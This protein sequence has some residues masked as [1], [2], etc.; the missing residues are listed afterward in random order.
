MNFA[1]KINFIFANSPEKKGGIFKEIRYDIKGHNNAQWTKLNPKKT[2]SRLSK[3]KKFDHGFD[4]QIHKFE[5]STL[6]SNRY[7]NIYGQ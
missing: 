7:W 1:Y 4:S 3:K 5:Y 2:I 6:T